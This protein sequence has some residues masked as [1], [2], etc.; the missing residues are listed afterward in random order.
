MEKAT[1]IPEKEK[2]KSPI[3]DGIITFLSYFF[4]LPVFIILHK[5]LPDPNWPLHLD[6]VLLATAI[7]FLI[8]LLLNVFKPVILIGFVLAIVWLTYGSIRKKYGFINFYNDYKVLLYSMANS[9]NPEH[10]AITELKAFPLK[11]QVK[12]AIDYKSEKVRNLAVKLAS[13]NF[14]KFK[15]GIYNKHR[16]TI[17]SFSIFKE[18][19]SRWNYVSDPESSEY[20]AK[21]SETADLFAGDCDDHAVFMSACLKAIGARPRMIHTT[22]H[23]YPEI[24]IGDK[25]DLEE[26]NYLIREKLFV[27]ETKGQSLHYH[28]DEKGNIWLNLDYTE[29]FPGGRFMDEEILGVILLD[30]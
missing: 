11:S 5:V 7:Y 4:V 18:I 2:E 27:E 14:E 20:F 12:A 6:R 17:Q 23:L 28:I 24:Y 9:P 30:D 25:Q 29:N 16:V 26:I 22:G 15:E 10:I 19:N 8:R 1:E 21:A 3:T 13:K